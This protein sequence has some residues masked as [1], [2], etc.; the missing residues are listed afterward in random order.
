MCSTGSGGLRSSGTSMVSSLEAATRP[1]FFARSDG[2][3]LD[4]AARPGFFERSNGELC[5]STVWPTFLRRG[6]GEVLDAVIRSSGASM[7]SCGGD[8]RGR[9][10]PVCW[11]GQEYRLGVAWRIEH[12]A[13]G[14][15]RSVNLVGVA[16][17]I[18]RFGRDQECTS[19]LEY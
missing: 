16:P 14:S 10:R 15:R 2:E 9:R 4:A 3:H 1:R 19:G 6:K 5:G 13:L 18:A 17:V 7:A 11:P 12:W 8:L